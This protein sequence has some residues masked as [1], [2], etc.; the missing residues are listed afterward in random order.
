[1]LFKESLVYVA[2]NT[3]IRWIKLFHLYKGFHRKV[4]RTG[5]FVKGSARVVEPPRIEYKGFKYKYSIKG[6]IARLLLVRVTKVNSS[7]SLFT[8]KFPSNEGIV[9]KK[10]QSPLSKFLLG[11]VSRIATKRRKMMTLFKQTV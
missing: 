5:F 4:T 3:N 2:D 7:K 9:V 10:Q 8:I 1:M 11:P 6:D